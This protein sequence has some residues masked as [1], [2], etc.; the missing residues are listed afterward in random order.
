MNRS[1]SKIEML[2]KL[3]ICMWRILLCIRLIVVST[4]TSEPAV[5]LLLLP[6]SWIHRSTHLSE[7]LAV[8]GKFRFDLH[9]RLYMHCWELMGLW[10][11]EL[12]LFRVSVD[13]G[14]FP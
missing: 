1:E 2:S 4:E 5:E 10:A 9:I 14:C 11:A 8:D 13:R 6:P 3:S 12:L 7:W